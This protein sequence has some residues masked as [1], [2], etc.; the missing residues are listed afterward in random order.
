[1]MILLKRHVGFLYNNMF[2]FLSRCLI[3]SLLTRGLKYQRKHNNLQIAFS[4][5]SKA[6][7]GLSLSLSLSLSVSLF[8]CLFFFCILCLC[9]WYKACSFYILIENTSTHI[10][11][12]HVH[13][14][15]SFMGGTKL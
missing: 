11:Q 5:Q 1:M 13:F 15:S 12:V 4:E 6:I 7:Q 9:F 14:L 3:V 10:H 8:L 2:C